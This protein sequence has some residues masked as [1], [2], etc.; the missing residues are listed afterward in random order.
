M[1]L[2]LFNGN[3]IMLTE[4]QLKTIWAG[5]SVSI[6]THPQP[7][8]RGDT[9][10]ACLEGDPENSEFWDII[11]VSDVKSPSRIVLTTCPCL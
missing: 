5:K 10:C 3:A 2:T 11:Y 6:K 8:M 7:Y 4:K 9:L 1:K